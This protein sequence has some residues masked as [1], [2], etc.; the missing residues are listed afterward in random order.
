MSLQFFEKFEGLSFVSIELLNQFYDQESLTEDEF[1]QL[2][3]LRNRYHGLFEQN[4]ANQNLHI[5]AK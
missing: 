4:L 5:R 1:T 3:L 2:R